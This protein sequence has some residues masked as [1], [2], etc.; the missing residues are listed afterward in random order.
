MRS[1]NDSVKE[2]AVNSSE[3]Y[4]TSSNKEPEAGQ[5]NVVDQ[6]KVSRDT[7]YDGVHED[8]ESD[9][10][11]DGPRFDTGYEYDEVDAKSFFPSP[12]RES[13]S[14][15]ESPKKDT[16]SPMGRVGFVDNSVK[17]DLS[18][19]QVL[20]LKTETKKSTFSAIKKSTNRVDQGYVEPSYTW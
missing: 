5:R 16:S 19:V 4:E 6:E 10:D 12:D 13:F 8:D 18:D 2:N 7:K 17:Y 1:R 3:T 15:P 14:P 11:D 9:S 20:K